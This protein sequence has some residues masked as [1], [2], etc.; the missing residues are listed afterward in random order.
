MS[1]PSEH[2]AQIH[3]TNP[4]ERLNREIRRRTDVVS[5]FQNRPSVLRLVG[6]L[7][8]EQ[9]EDW[10]IGRKYFSKESMNKMVNPTLAPYTL[11]LTS[12]LYK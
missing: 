4:L 5:I 10:Q 1:F 9:H 11:A 7:L 8:I 12:L 6:A 2:W 3:S